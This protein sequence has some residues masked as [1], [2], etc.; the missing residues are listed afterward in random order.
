MH[1]IKQVKAD[2]TK[3]ASATATRVA[4][5]DYGDDDSDNSD[6]DCNEGGG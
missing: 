2:A 3:R 6:G 5:D 4:S 1:P